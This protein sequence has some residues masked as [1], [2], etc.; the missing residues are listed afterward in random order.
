MADAQPTAS[1]PR[2]I[3][4]ADRSSV[5]SVDALVDLAEIFEPS[6]NIVRLARVASPA[7]LEEC[8][9]ELDARS[10]ARMMI[11]R[12]GP[13]GAQ[14]VRSAL[15]SAPHLAEDVALLCEVLAELTGAERIG[16]RL[17]VVES[18]MCP[19][20]HVDRVLVRAVCTYLGHGTEFV[21]NDH[22][23]RSKLGHA[24]KGAR[25]EDSGLLSSV[26]RILAAEHGELVLLKGEAWPDNEGRGAVHR[27]PAASDA[28]PRLVL[29]L[30][31]L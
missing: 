24:A 23:D 4:A 30:D 14:D 8:R 22:V 20:F 15:P 6:V 12:A 21:S 10:A 29:T 25:D 9:R 3:D 1:A 28:T 11:V 19:R 16:A 17:A 31:P 26:E 13:D 27:S 18:A 5:R 2:R 7:L